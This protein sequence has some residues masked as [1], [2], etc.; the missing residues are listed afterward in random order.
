VLI[1]CP[2]CREDLELSDPDARGPIRCPCC[3]GEFD[4]F[5]DPPAAF[6]TLIQKTIGPDGL[7][8]DKPLLDF[9]TTAII[10]S[11]PDA[12][13]VAPPPPPAVAPPRRPAIRRPSGGLAETHGPPPLPSRRAV[14]IHRDTAAVSAVSLAVI[15]GC[16]IGMIR[17]PAAADGGARTAE[18]AG[19]FG[20]YAG[21]EIASTGVRTVVV[22]FVP[23]QGPEKYEVLVLYSREHQLNLDELSDGGNSFKPEMLDA[24]MTAVAE[25]KDISHKE[26]DVLPD[27]VRVVSGSGLRLAFDDPAAAERAGAVLSDVTV[28][29]AGVR[30]ENL[31]P[32]REAECGAL[33]CVGTEDRL[34][35]T[36]MDIGPGDI[37]GGFYTKSGFNSVEVL[38]TGL[39][40]FRKAVEADIRGTDGR[41]DPSRFRAAA[42]RLR[43][44]LL[45]KPLLE[46]REANA[47]TAKGRNRVVLIGGAAWVLA[48]LTHPT[49]PA[50]SRLVQL[51][52]DDFGQLDVLVANL[53]PSLD[54]IQVR[55]AVRERVLTP[56]GPDGAAGTPA[57]K[58]VGDVLEAFAGPKLVAAGMT[59]AALYDAYQLGGKRVD[60]F[61]K[62]LYAMLI[63][64][65]IE[66]SGVE[67]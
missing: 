4:P 32:S 31:N 39:R 48:T 67:K 53:P 42:A 10:P 58:A 29:A 13:F 47:P 16:V 46:H 28:K 27:R 25:F 56:L 62:G 9:D 43:P 14:T 49:P 51:T 64:Y 63:G 7:P 8:L 2:H 23:K 55:A 11:E 1:N 3:D 21:V 36:F 44:T 60:F 41:P 50:D 65:L 30:V 18:P 57:D 59:T 6:R 5:D 20:R 38:G 54:P 34:D 26:F 52:A 22:E 17:L 37:K 12:P 66:T 33:A 61:Y 45:D 19:R 15:L 24:V 40:S 35:T